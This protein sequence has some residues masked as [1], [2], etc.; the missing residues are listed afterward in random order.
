VQVPTE[1][2]D[3]LELDSQV[4]VSL[5]MWMQEQYVFLTTEQSPNHDPE[6]LSTYVFVY[7]ELS[8]TIER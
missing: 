5:P 6:V 4:D 3:L 2:W 8:E 1:V 7:L